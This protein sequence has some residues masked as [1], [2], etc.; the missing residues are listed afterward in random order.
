MRLRLLDPL[1]VVV[2][3][4]R[5][6]DLLAVEV[7]V[8]PREHAQLAGARVRVCR[9]HVRLPPVEG[10]GLARRDEQRLRGVGVAL[11]PLA[12]AC[13]GG[14]HA[15]REVDVEHAQLAPLAGEHL[16]Q[17]DRQLTPD[18]AGGLR[19][20][21]PAS[22]SV[23]V[24]LADHVVE[25]VAHVLHV[26]AREAPG[27]LVA[28]EG[29]DPLAPAPALV[30]HG[31][32]ARRLA[33]LEVVVVPVVARLAVRRRGLRDRDPALLR[34]AALVVGVVLGPLS[35]V[36]PRLEVDALAIGERDLRLEVD[37]AA[38]V[39]ELLDGAAALVVGGV[40]ARISHPQ[41]ARLRR[42]AEERGELL[43]GLR[44]GPVAIGGELAV[45]GV[46]HARAVD[47]GEPP[48]RLPPPPSGKSVERPHEAD[49]NDLASLA[50]NIAPD[51][52]TVRLS[53]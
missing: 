10:D 28:D 46:H 18:V 9:D 50:T 19:G 25:R 30:L 39:L 17:R 48:L 7:D 36:E 4:L 15:R 49:A 20:E 14:L 33:R 21:A 53:V 43:G 35:L 47:G 24:V 29:R 3:R 5:D 26:V 32:V 52:A 51:V 37:A 2:P 41:P 8:A 11:E 27:G 6:A 42:A 44:P 22:A 1:V 13:L 23:L 31:R 34:L 16:A 45:R 38:R 12:P 40:H